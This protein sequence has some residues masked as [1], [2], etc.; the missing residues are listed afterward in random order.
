MGRCPKLDFQSGY[1]DKYICKLTG[2]QMDTDDP[3]VK[4]TCKAE[5]DAKYKKCEI[6][7]KYA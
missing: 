5:D 7:D 6:Y 3:K 1:F 2:Q 4:Y